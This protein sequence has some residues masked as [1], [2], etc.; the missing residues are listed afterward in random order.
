MTLNTDA[1]GLLKYWLLIYDTVAGHR[2]HRS[3]CL[4]ASSISRFSW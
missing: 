1:T 2:T 4:I 3:F